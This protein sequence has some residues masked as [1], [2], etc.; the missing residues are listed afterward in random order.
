MIVRS[1]FD[2][3]YVT[4]TKIPLTFLVLDGGLLPV[5]KNTIRG[6]SLSRFPWDGRI[7]LRW[8]SL[9]SFIG[10]VIASSSSLLLNT[11]VF[12]NM[13]SSLDLSMPVSGRKLKV[14]HG[15][16]V[17]ILIDSSDFGFSSMLSTSAMDVGLMTSL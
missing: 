13:Y 3:T 7:S 8:A 1:W 16:I 14:V 11:F 6:Y 4:C 5:P 15:L 17:V 10:A 2:I 12:C 9:Y